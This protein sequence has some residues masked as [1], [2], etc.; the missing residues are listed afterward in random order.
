MKD[1]QA[2]HESEV[3]VVLAQ[4]EKWEQLSKERNLLACLCIISTSLTVPG[5]PSSHFHVKTWLPFRNNEMDY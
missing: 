2:L 3:K 5:Q 1:N 4:L